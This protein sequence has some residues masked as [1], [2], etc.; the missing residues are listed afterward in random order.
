[1]LGMHGEMQANM[2]AQQSDLVIAI[3]ARFSDRVT[4]DT[5]SFATKA[6]IIHI[7]IDP[8]EIGKNMR[9]DYSATCDVRLALEAIIPMLEPQDR[10]EW[11][12]KIDT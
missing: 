2:A 5:S 12:K 1:M 8:S 9:Y 3:G 11:T 6:K 10:T 4:G 7:D